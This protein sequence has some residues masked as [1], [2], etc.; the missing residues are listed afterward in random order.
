MN[1]DLLKDLIG[2]LEDNAMEW[3]CL[4]GGDELAERNEKLLKRLREIE[5]AKAE[6]WKKGKR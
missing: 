3:R 2:L 6:T 1:K 5:K 4:D